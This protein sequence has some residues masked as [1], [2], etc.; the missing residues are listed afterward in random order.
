VIE[1]AQ[2]GGPS[3]LIDDGAQAVVVTRGGDG[4]DVQ[5]LRATGR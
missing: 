3:A 4:A 5:L 1:A 2:L